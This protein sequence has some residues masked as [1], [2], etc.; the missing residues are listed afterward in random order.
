[1]ARGGYVKCDGEP[2]LIIALCNSAN[3][4]DITTN[5]LFSGIPKGE[6]EKSEA[7]ISW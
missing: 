4:S 7:V 3:A 2:V 1:M 5:I 6:L